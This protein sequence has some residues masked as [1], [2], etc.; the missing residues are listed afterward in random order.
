MSAAIMDF[1]AF[2]DNVDDYHEEVYALYCAVNDETDMG[3][4]KCVAGNRAG[5]WIVKSSTGIEDLFL[6]SQAAKQAFLKAIVDRF[7]GDEEDGMDIEGWYHYNRAMEND[8]D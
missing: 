7:V 2:L 6:A 1:D 3:L 8:K 5:T 4:F